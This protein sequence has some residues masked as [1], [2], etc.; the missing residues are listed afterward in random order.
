MKCFF[1]NKKKKIENKAF[2]GKQETV[3]LDDGC[4]K[5]L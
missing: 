5:L 4:A 3:L 2:Q 1:V